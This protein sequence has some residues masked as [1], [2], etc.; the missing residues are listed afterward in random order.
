MFVSENTVN[1]KEMQNTSC[2]N[3]YSYPSPLAIYHEKPEETHLCHT[4]ENATSIRYNFPT[5][6]LAINSPLF[7]DSNQTLNVCSYPAGSNYIYPGNFHLDT[8]TYMGCLLETDEQ[9]EVKDKSQSKKV[10]SPH[11]SNAPTAVQHRRRGRRESHNEVERKRRN[12]IND[13]IKSLGQLL[14]ETL[15]Q[16]KLNKGTI[17][18]SSVTY[19]HM[20]N[21]QLMQYKKQLEFLQYE[22][23]KLSSECS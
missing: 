13:N 3:R 4:A 10:E 1:I 6:S 20:L 12:N 22:A 11:K 19:I 5:D 18:Q 7:V 2:E 9:H 17:L 16:G 14:P 23:A 15:C 8:S 21:D